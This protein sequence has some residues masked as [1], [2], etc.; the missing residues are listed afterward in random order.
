MPILNP[1]DEEFTG[2]LAAD[3]PVALRTALEAARSAHYDA[4]QNAFDYAGF[5]RSPEYESLRA[6]AR[7]WPDSIAA[8][9]ASGSGCRSGST[10]TTRWCCTR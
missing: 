1:N 5:G 10:S 3:P 8:C 2:E 4:A 6:A 9:S 7:R